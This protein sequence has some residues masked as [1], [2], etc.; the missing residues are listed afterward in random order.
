MPEKTQSETER[1]LTRAG[2]GAGGGCRNSLGRR[3]R[4][5]PLNQVWS[6]RVLP[7][8]AFWG[9]ASMHLQAAGALYAADGGAAQTSMFTG[10]AFVQRPQSVQVVASRLMPMNEN[11]LKMPLKAPKGQA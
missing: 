6:V 11:E 10:Q 5:S 1:R 3:I 4:P 9:Q 2:G 7:V 8:L